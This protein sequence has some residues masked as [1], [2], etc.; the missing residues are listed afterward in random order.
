ML[1]KLSLQFHL[2]K[3]NVTNLEAQEKLKHK[4]LQC[5]KLP[6]ECHF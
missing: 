5:Q 1:I 4:L 2:G 6:L 3:L